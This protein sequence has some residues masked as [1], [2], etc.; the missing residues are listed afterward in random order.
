MEIQTF[1]LCN[2][3]TR[4]A[5]GT[6]CNAEMLGVHS[7]FAVDGV[8][9][10]RFAMPYFVLLRRQDRSEVERFA[11]RFDLVNPDGRPIGEP[12]GFSGTGAFPAG[13]RFCTVTGTIAF[14]FP[15]IGDYRL[16]ITADTHGIACVF[17][18]DIEVTPAP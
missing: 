4:N 9:P 12:A 17:S 3:V 14:A 15:S 8:F 11:L 7:F 10:L 5:Q 1:L 2:S 16:D 6:A 13:A 18:Y